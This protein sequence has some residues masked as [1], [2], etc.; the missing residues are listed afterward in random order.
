[1]PSESPSTG[2]LDFVNS[3]AAPGL[4]DRP[5]VHPTLRGKEVEV[6]THRAHTRRTSDSCLRLVLSA[7]F[8][9]GLVMPAVQRVLLWLVWAFLECLFVDLQPPSW[10]V[11]DLDIPIDGH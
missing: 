6:G 10:L 1:M 7:I 2:Q 3:Q 5:F 8:L 4:A 11:G 9:Q